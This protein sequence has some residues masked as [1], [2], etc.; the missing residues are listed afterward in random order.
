L[1]GEQHAVGVQVVQRLEHGVE[2]SLHELRVA[3]DVGAAGADLLAGELPPALVEDVDVL[4]LPTALALAQPEAPHPAGATHRGQGA[5]H[6]ALPHPRVELAAELRGQ[7]R[8][9]GVKR[10]ERLELARV[11]LGRLAD[12]IHGRVVPG[13]ARRLDLDLDVG[14]GDRPVVGATGACLHRCPRLV[15]GQLPWP[16]LGGGPGHRGGSGGLGGRLRGL[17]LD[18]PRARPRDD[19]R[20][21]GLK[22]TDRLLPVTLTLLPRPRLLVGRRFD[23][24]R[25]VAPGRRLRSG[26]SVSRRARTSL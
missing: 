21:L 7:Q 3:V 15:A 13:E 22:L 19:R 8:P 14:L 5:L 1:E 24:H 26:L 16:G 6:G 9:E 10:P 18:D 20:L 25:W 17:L 11:G 12:R 23:D 4:G 2:A